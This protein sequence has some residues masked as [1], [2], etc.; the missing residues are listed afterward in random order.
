MKNPTFSCAIVYVYL[1]DPTDTF[2]NCNKPVDMALYVKKVLDLVRAA[3]VMVKTCIGL[4]K[5][6]Y[7]IHKLYTLP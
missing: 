1:W 3:V 7:K 5:G 4:L 2:A 6:S